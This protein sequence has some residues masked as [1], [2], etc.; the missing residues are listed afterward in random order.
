[1]YIRIQIIFSLYVSE[2]KTGIYM[3]CSKGVLH[4]VLIP[5]VILKLYLVRRNAKNFL[6][7]RIKKKLY[8]SVNKQ[9]VTIKHIK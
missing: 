4:I 5:H 1:M 9:I 8:E 3:D 6:I 2:S 7:N